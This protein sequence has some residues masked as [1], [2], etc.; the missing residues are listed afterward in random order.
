MASTDKIGVKKYEVR[1]QDPGRPSF[2]HVG[3]TTGTSYADTGLA[4]GSNYIYGVPVRD[5][6]EGLKEYSGVASVTTASPTIN[7]RT[8]R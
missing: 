4:S 1:R 8:A 5:A 3:M 6:R 2:V 7:P